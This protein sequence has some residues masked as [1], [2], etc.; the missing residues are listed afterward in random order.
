MNPL[1]TLI[2]QS[3]PGIVQ[4]IQEAHAANDPNA[5]PLTPEQ[6]ADLFEQ[7]FSSTIAR[8]EVIKA[9]HGWS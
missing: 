5:V 9:A 7:A 1:V 6:V 8:D 4:R 3:I 2:I